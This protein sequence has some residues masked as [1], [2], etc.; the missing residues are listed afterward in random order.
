[1]P[2]R[3]ADTTRCVRRDGPRSRGSLRSPIFRCRCVP[4]ARIVVV[5]HAIVSSGTGITAKRVP[6]AT[7]PRRTTGA[8]ERLRLGAGKSAEMIHERIFFRD[9]APGTIRTRVSSA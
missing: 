4:L 2:I 1:M 7:D 3:V 9:V 5:L 6:C 8:I